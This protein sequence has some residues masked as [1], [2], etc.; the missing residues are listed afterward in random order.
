M[1]TILENNITVCG[2][3]ERLFVGIALIASVM[4]FGEVVPAWVTLLAVYPVI[5]AIML[6]DPIFAAVLKM[7]SLV[8]PLE[9]GRKTPLVS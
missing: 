1:N 3:N 2:R 6:W 7:R 5:T 9:F 4:F 8:G